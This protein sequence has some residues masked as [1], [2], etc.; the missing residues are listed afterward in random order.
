MRFLLSIFLLVFTTV[1][2]QKYPSKNYTTSEGLQNNAV[3][4]LFVDK[5][6]VLWVGTEN[7]VSRFINGQFYNLS[8]EDGLGHNSCWDISQDSDGNMW[9]A[10]YGGGI[11]KF[12]GKKFTLFSAKNGLPSDKIRK[13]FPFKNNI[14]V[15]T[16]QGISI[17]D[18]KTS[19]IST[20]KVPKTK[21]DF[22]CID[23]FVYHNDVYFISVFD[24]VFKIDESSN[25]PK[26][27]PV[28]LRSNFYSAFLDNENLH[29]SNEGFIEKINIQELL[30]KNFK[31][32]QF[33][34][35]II[36]Q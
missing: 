14:Y 8:E 26:I 12:D 11:S 13:V 7:G 9:F 31:L 16:E 4:S 10:S 27:V 32:V 6:H 25:S 22:I 36:H 35:S 30:H 1:F 3:R 2:A 5:D 15:G 33:G 19:K 23:F 24:G 17:I 20:P 21:E 34:N 18:I 28:Y 29:L